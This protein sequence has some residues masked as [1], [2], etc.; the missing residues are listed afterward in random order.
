MAL[1]ET[2]A[3]LEHLLIMGRLQ[4]GD[5]PDSVLYRR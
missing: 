2:I 4:P 1:R 3:H 5:D